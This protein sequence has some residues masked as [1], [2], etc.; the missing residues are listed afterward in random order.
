MN[1]NEFADII[2]ADLV[3]KRYA[4]QKIGLFAHL[5]ALK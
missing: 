4:N 2:G 1:I 3:I 5:I